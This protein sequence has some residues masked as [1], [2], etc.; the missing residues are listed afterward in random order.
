MTVIPK[1][2]QMPQVVLLVL[3]EL[4][5]ARVTWEKEPQVR[6]CPHQT[7]LWASL[8]GIVLVDD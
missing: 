2:R 1:T 6:K 5:E 7:V 4:K 3:C 8:R